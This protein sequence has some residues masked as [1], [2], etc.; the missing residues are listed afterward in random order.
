M[1]YHPITFDVCVSISYNSGSIFLKDPKVILLKGHFQERYN[2][3]LFVSV[4]T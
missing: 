3:C 2:L 1:N 4:G